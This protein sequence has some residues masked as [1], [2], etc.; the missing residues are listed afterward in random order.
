MKLTSLNK[1]K[2]QN[3]DW[4]VIDFSLR[5]R[6]NV[7]KGYSLNSWRG[8]IGWTPPECVVNNGSN[9]KIYPQFD[10]WCI[11]LVILYMV[12]GQNPFELTLE[13]CKQNKLYSLEA[14]KKY[15]FHQKLLKFNENNQWSHYLNFLHKKNKI[16]LDLLDLLLNHMLVFDVKKRSNSKNVLKHKWFKDIAKIKKINSRQKSVIISK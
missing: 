14:G 10:V 2:N 5:T 11:G 6:F 3:G 15:W 4:R 7:N 12:I 1:N 13:E 8:T 9:N 16:S